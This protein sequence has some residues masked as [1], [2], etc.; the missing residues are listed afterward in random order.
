MDIVK[1]ENGKY[2]VRRRTWTGYKF[3]NLGI[4]HI[5]S[6]QGDPYFNQCMT[7]DRKIAEDAVGRFEKKWYVVVT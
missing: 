6:K 1:F 4:P 7:H 5:W 3:L 2:G